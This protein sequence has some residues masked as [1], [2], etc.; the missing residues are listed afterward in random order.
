M[1]IGKTVRSVPRHSSA[2][3]FT[4]TK[5]KSAYNI[6]SGLQSGSIRWSLGET[7][8]LGKQKAYHLRAPW[9]ARLACLTV[10]STAFRVAS[11][12][13]RTPK[14]TRGSVSVG[15]RCG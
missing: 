14:F 8:I 2:L 15:L 4:V 10:V 6:C 13:V 1:L 3:R 12:S 11:K 7:G 5:L 9:R